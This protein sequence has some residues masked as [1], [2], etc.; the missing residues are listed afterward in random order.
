MDLLAPGQNDDRGEG[1]E[2]QPEK[3]RVMDQRIGS[4]I[5]GR[6]HL[7]KTQGGRQ[8]KSPQRPLP[9]ALVVDQ[10]TSPD[11]RQPIPDAHGD[12]HVG[13][14][15]ED[16]VQ[17]AALSVRSRVEQDQE[18]EA[19]E[20]V[21][22]SQAEE[23]GSFAGLEPF[24]KKE[25][26]QANR[27][28]GEV[29]FLHRTAD[30]HRDLLGQS[31][32]AGRG[33]D[34]LVLASREGV[35]EAGDRAGVTPVKRRIRHARQRHVKIEGCSERPNPSADQRRHPFFAHLGGS[36]DQVN[37]QRHAGEAD[38]VEHGESEHFQID[39]VGLIKQV[40][41][42]GDGSED[43]QEVGQAADERKVP[44]QFDG[45]L[46][47]LDQEHHPDDARGDANQ[48]VNDEERVVIA[49]D[50]DQPHAPPDQTSEVDEGVPKEEVP[51]QLGLPRQNGHLQAHGHDEER[52]VVVKGDAKPEEGE[53]E[54]ASLVR[55]VNP[56]QEADQH[57]HEGKHAQCVNLHDNGLAPHKA[58][59]AHEH[60]RHKTRHHAERA[61]RAALEVLQI[62]NAF[63]HHAA[64]PGDEQSDQTAA[65]RPRDRRGKAN[66]KSNVGHRDEH[67]K[68]PRVDRPHR[69][70]GRVGHS[71]V[72][73]GDGELP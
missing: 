17:V 48:I 69:V 55:C 20:K 49:Q 27:Q 51:A 6:G 4:L 40:D 67:G 71:G 19:Q 37:H 61:F 39:A 14:G 28:I 56:A 35:E 41:E 66:A 10:Q 23:P 42:V 72:H 54:I 58:V 5:E 15:K 73:R 2:S 38:E 47:G 68:K 31:E 9:I 16:L 45:A 3:R 34:A 29:E 52:L 33:M 44:G 64:A 11:H 25:R 65:Q 63:D 57:A 46:L 26:N 7:V 8:R 24:V 70:A 13:G 18:K 1:R 59:E 32:G 21:G 30:V 12:H 43:N 62:G 22:G 50:G 53:V 60:S 36:F